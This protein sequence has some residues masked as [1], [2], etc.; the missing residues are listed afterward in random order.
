M[1]SCASQEIVANI[2]P[3]FR[4][5]LQTLTLLVNHLRKTW[6]SILKI[7]IRS[8]RSKKFYTCEQMEHLSHHLFT[9]K[10]RK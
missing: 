5:V 8:R 9:S 4:I 3:I 7:D 6:N 2:T 10:K 1:S